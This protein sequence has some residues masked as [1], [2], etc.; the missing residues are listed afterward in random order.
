[1]RHKNEN[2]DDWKVLGYTVEDGVINLCIDNDDGHIS[3]YDIT[4]IELELD[5][6]LLQRMLSDLQ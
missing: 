2:P 4:S 6:E 5:K 1:M 3:G